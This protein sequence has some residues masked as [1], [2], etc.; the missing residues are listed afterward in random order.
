MIS[1][2]EKL[3]FPLIKTQLIFAFI[4][5]VEACI[6]EFG[7]VWAF[8]L[9][10]KA[11]LCSGSNEISNSGETCTYFP[12][13]ILFSPISLLKK[14]PPFPAPFHCHPQCHTKSQPWKLREESSVSE[15]HVD[16]PQGKK[17]PTRINSYSFTFRPL[18]F[19]PSQALL[20]M[21]QEFSLL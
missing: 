1:Y 15:P 19:P 20:S 3:N 13:P 14:T 7:W 4:A 2:T 9:W 11:Q 12:S 21:L 6:S 5:A 17:N 8:F 18:L 10:Y 16:I